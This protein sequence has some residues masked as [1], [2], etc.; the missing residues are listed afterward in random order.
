M[1]K[2]KHSTLIR[3]LVA[4]SAT[5]C[6]CLT[7]AETVYKTCELIPAGVAVNAGETAAAKLQFECVDGYKLTGWSATLRRNRAPEDFFKQTKLPIKKHKSNSDFDFVILRTFSRLP[8]ALAK[9]EVPLKLSTKNMV[10][11][12]YAVSIRCSFVKDKVTT[13]KARDFHITI[14]SAE[15][16]AIMTPKSKIAPLQELVIP[17]LTC[18]G[19]PGS[20]LGADVPCYDDFRIASWPDK[21]PENATR[22]KLF[23]DNSYVYIG[24]EAFEKHMDKQLL[25]SSRSNTIWS[26]ECIEINFDPKGAKLLL[27]KIFI[28]PNGN[29][30]EMYGEDDNTGQEKFKF[31]VGRSFGS[32]LISVKRHSDK[33]TVE[34]K[35][36]IGAFY[37]GT[38][39]DKFNALFNIGRIRHSTGKESS[40]MVPVNRRTQNTP[41][42]YAKLKLAGFESKYFNWQLEGLAVKTV[43]EAGK[44]QAV[45]TARVLNN[46]GVFRNARITAVLL[47]KHGNKVT[48][49]SSFY[50]VLPKKLVPVQLT[51]ASET[52]GRHHVVMEI[53]D[54]QGVLLASQSLDFN[55]EYSPVAIEVTQPY[56]RNNIYATMPEVKTIKAN[57]RVSEPMSKPLTVT[58]TG[59]NYNKS[60]TIEKPQAVNLVEFPFSGTAEGSYTL[61]A[62][63]AKTVI[64]KLPYVKGEVWFDKN[65]VTYVDGK[66]YM[67]FGGANIPLEW[68]TRGVNTIS[69]YTHFPSVEKLKEWLDDVH[70][71]GKK[72]IFQPFLAPPPTRPFSHTGRMAGKI[73][74]EQ[75]ALLKEL[76]AVTVNHPAVLSYRIAEEPEGWGHNEDWYR[77]AYQLMQELDPYHPVNITNYG[78]PGQRRFA[79]YCD[80][81]WPDSYPD[82]FEDGSTRHSR[83]RTYEDS[84]FADSVHPAW[85]IIHCFDWGKR[86]V[87]NSP[88]RPPTYDELREQAFSAYLGNIKGLFIFCYHTVGMF[89]DQLRIGR[90]YLPVELAS[91]K[92]LLLCRTEDAVKVNKPDIITGLKRNKKTV[93]IIAVNLGDKTQDVTFKSS[94]P[95]P[96]SLYVNGEKR[97]VKVNNNSFT[98]KIAPHT[99]VVYMAG[100]FEKDAVVIEDVRKEIAAVNRGR[101]K[102]G[103]LMAAGEFTF[104]QMKDYRNG[105]IPAGIPRMSCSSEKHHWNNIASAYFLQDGLV[106]DDY[107]RG[108]MAWTPQAG[109][110]SPWVEVDFGKTVTVSRSVITHGLENHSFI[111][112]GTLLAA[113]ESGKFREIAQFKDNKPGVLEI[114]HAP[115]KVRKL[116]LQMNRG[117]S[118]LLLHEWEVYEK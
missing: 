56:Y 53:R 40:S 24:I 58:L 102:P 83:W 55:L 106:V 33:W 61:Q 47:D 20:V 101:F 48:E 28:D 34:L 76:L 39:N 35:L 67:P 37:D 99:A 88:G 69:T 71:A 87:K 100:E 26:R 80:L 43:K 59:P 9:G 81:M 32:Q 103:N 17:R 107:R 85:I 72:A 22:V 79:P 91:M 60:V 38:P 98:D 104:C 49:Q 46:T 73:S 68:N 41:S 78:I 57:I 84:K 36:P 51:L 54:L 18:S 114:K 93:G 64:R 23:H 6:T 2:S 31:N 94:I 12:D 16:S 1:K 13:V 90:N 15:P 111:K 82:Y 113:D 112:S 10:P 77:E 30:V 29:K 52:S 3:L 19:L 5:C 70:K 108:R 105:I 45:T 110:N 44:L 8:V 63:G 11:G 66:P 27:G 96:E 118:P 75:K 97:S 74:A 89:S 92:D 86:N 4:I 109:D 62:A 65:N 14:K 21:K 7:A 50:A 115:V 95:L 42:C 25:S 116:R 117:K